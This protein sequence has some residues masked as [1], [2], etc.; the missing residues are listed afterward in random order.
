MKIC[1]LGA[2]ILALAG[3]AKEPGPTPLAELSPPDARLVASPVALPELPIAAKG[4][5]PMVGSYAQCRA[6]YAD[7]ADRRLGL[8]SYIRA[9]R[10]V[11]NK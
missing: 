4:N 6:S 11:A 9:A 7:E 10:T 2:L 3:C 1:A 5:G 8:I